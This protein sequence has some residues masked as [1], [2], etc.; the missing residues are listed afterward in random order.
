MAGSLYLN[1]LSRDQY[2]ALLKT[3]WETQQKLC[4][5][6]DQ[7]IDLVLHA[8]SIHV[9]HITPLR[10][11]G[12]DDPTNFA[13]THAH[14]NT[15]KL[16]SDLQVA[17]LLARFERLSEESPSE[18][19][20]PNL[21]DVLLHYAGARFDLP[22]RV[23]TGCVEY[24]LPDLGDNAITKVPL[25]HDRQ[26]NMEYF[27]TA[28]PIEYLLHDDRINPRAIAVASLRKLIEEFHAGLPQLQVALAWIETKPGQRSKVRV[29][30]GQHKVAAQVLLGAKVVPL[31]VFVNP[32]L[33]SLLTANTHAG[34]TLRQVAFDKS[35]Q[36]RLGSQLYADRIQRYLEDRELD[37]EYRGFSEKDLIDHFK[38]QWREVKRYILDDV[39]DVITHHEDNR[40]KGYIDFGGRGS[41]MPLSYSTIEKTF[42]SFFIYQDALTTP[43]DY[44]LE[45]GKNPRELEKEQIC[46]LM[47]LIAE[48]IYI[49]KYDSTVGTNRLESRVQQDE[50]ISHDHLRAVRMSKEEI[51]HTWLRMTVSLSIKTFFANQGVSFDEAR[52]FQYRFPDP[53][54]EVL[55]RLI[56]NL[57]A[58]PVWVNNSLSQTVFGGKQNYEYWRIIFET[59]KTPANQQVLAKPVNYLDLIRSS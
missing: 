55:G 7:P 32:N 33:D 56:G 4:F 21:S 59:G 58:L 44:L 28:L 3:L 31:R 38:G 27:F 18:P 37:P 23:S 57:A 12:K 41:E 19:N 50:P 42:Y 15:S 25:Y 2:Q 54:W 52:L 20:R 34:T 26:S 51:L 30:D 46:R 13:L 35:V 22:I 39:R 48:T 6:C 45:Q 5:I 10:A 16:T 11:A 17:R 49:G 29:F 43:L 8:G 9:D 40:L 1:S 53:L 47:S 36:R 24:S 14:C